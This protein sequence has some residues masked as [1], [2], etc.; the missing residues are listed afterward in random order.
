M[1]ILNRKLLRDLWQSKGQFLSVLVIVMIGVMFYTGI[2]AAFYNLSGASEKYYREYRLA[3]LWAGF[4]RAPEN[5]EDKIESLP[6]V[7]MAAGRIVQDV[8]ID[9]DGQNA[10]IRLITLPDQKKDIVNDIIITSGRYFSNAE[11]N[12]C[13]VEEGFYKAYNL[14]PGDYIFPVVGGKE[15]KLNVV[16]SVKSPEYVYP[17]REG[18]LVPDNKKFGIVYIKKSFG[19]A[20][21]GFSGSINDLSLIFSEGT[22]LDQAKEDVKKFLK[23]FNVTEAIDRDS[24]ISTKM[25]SEEMKGLKSTGGS[26][27]IVFF[28]YGSR[29]YIHNNGQDGR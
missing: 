5:V 2:N 3:D 17:L 6:F 9:M 20:I 12:Q 7:K 29:H 18:E 27:P 15:V 11:S 28:H 4:Y 26:F 1:D 10:A 21:L 14:K 8:K 16:G 22:D 23:E 13:L 25:L 19:Q 24:Q